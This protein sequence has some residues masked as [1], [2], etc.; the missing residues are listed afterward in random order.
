MIT[1]KGI[2]EIH[3]ANIAR[4]SLG[5]YSGAVWPAPYVIKQNYVN[6]YLRT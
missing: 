1:H 6:N 5:L 3:L 2:L 4:H